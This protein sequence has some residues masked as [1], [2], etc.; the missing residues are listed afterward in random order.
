MVKILCFVLGDFLPQSPK[1]RVFLSHHTFEARGHFMDAH[2]V[3]S[4][5]MCQQILKW[6]VGEEPGCIKLSG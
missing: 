3:G 4:R 6:G 1:K 5:G 2:A